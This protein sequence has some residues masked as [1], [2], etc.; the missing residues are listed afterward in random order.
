[1]G[2]AGFRL[3]N[4]NEMSNP[5]SVVVAGASGRAPALLAVLRDGG[6]TLRLALTTSLSELV[7]AMAETRWDLILVAQDET[8]SLDLERVLAIAEPLRT[9]VIVVA[10]SVDP[11]AGRA[12]LRAGAADVIWPTQIDR[13][14]LAAERVLLQTARAENTAD[15]GDLNDQPDVFSPNRMVQVL[16]DPTTGRMVDAN[17]AAAE[18]Y[19]FRLDELRGIPLWRLNSD[20]N[21]STWADLLR[22]FAEP[23]G[24]VSARHRLADGRVRDVEIHASPV[25]RGSRLLVYGIINDVTEQRQRERE[26]ETV[27][28]FAAALRIA[29][30]RD[31]LVT[32]MVEQVCKLTG[33]TGAA[34]VLREAAHGGLA[35]TRAL[36]W[37]TAQEDLLVNAPPATPPA[38]PE[39]VSLT[40]QVVGNREPAW[41]NLQP[42]GD[43]AGAQQSFGICVPLVAQD[44]S[45]GALCICAELPPAAAQ[46]RLLIAMGDMAANALN[47][48]TLYEQTE[49][50]VQR[51]A[52]LHAIDIAITASFDLRVTLGIFLD[53]LVGQMSSR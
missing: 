9:P 22:A 27:S 44:Q 17:A 51:L 14:P 29:A 13:L 21:A 16:L 20:E 38:N 37:P 41:R 53:H 47:R 8:T 40:R 42:A 6:F 23:G 19:G 39:T 1:M 28:A 2:Q 49:Q 50:R 7:Q 4:Y 52:A 30:S 36:T 10:A 33:A 12:A 32:V 24:T 48:S 45:L 18:F 3:Q 34:L 35:L 25:Q 46:V 5:L 11:A 43:P 26:L 15:N 31:T